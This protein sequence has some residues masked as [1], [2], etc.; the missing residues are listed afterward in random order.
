[1]RFDPPA[2]T[3]S[4]RRKRRGLT[5][6]TVSACAAILL[7]I[8]S[9]SAWNYFDITLI[10]PSPSSTLDEYTSQVSAF[11]SPPSGK[12]EWS[13]DTGEP[14]VAPPVT[15][16]NLVYIVAGQRLDTGR[17]I[18]LNFDSGRQAWIYALHGVSDFK[19]TLAGA[20]V[21][22]VT[23]DGRVISLDRL[24]GQEK[25]VYDTGDLL[26][27][28]P[29][30]RKG[31]LYAASD[32]V[33]ALDAHTGEPMWIHRTESGRTITPLTYSEGIIAVMSEGN[34]L[35]L[36]DAVKG[37]RRLTTGLWFGGIGTPVISGD[38]VV[39]SGDR[40]SVQAVE[41]HA[42]DIPMEKALRFWWTK[43]WLYKS[44]PRPPDP[45]GY[46]W[47]H[48]GIGG[49]TAEVAAATDSRL[50]FVS[51]QDDHSA[52]VVFLDSASGTEIERFRPGAPVSER[53]TL[54]EGVLIV[55]TQDGRIHSMSAESGEGL[56]RYY[57]G[58]PIS[59]I[60][61]AEDNSLL[62]ASEDGV[63]HRVR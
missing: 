4:A 50:F 12:I 2:D 17:V 37:K 8:A 1:M 51:T 55:G 47:H 23:R 57:A 30:V 5:L 13:Y 46:L 20:N 7:L 59:A 24:S 38:A 21:Y 54:T 16:G 9:V 19:V 18:A 40:G 10:E 33:H 31:V 36:V 14:V 53:V 41:L 49:L 26:L 62:I 42:R 43:L 39:V 63:F 27:G 32:G 60:G 61:V 29:V 56:W 3:H 6:G 34:H 35:N 48:K 28:A 11:R 44:A 45:V 25:W 52:E 15:H 58:F 22:A